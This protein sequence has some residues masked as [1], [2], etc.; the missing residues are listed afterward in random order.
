MGSS[1]A[2]A[3]TA[4]TQQLEREHVGQARDHRVVAHP[5]HRADDDDLEQAA[6]QYMAA[7]PNVT[8]KI[9]VLENEAF[10]A[11]LTTAM[12]AGQSAGPLP[13]LGRRRAEAAGRRRPGQ[14]HHRRDVAPGSATSTRPR[15]G[16][17]PVR[18]QEV[19]RP[20]RPRHGRLLVQQGALRQGRHRRAADHLGRVPRRR[21][22]A[23]GR[24]HHPDRARREGQV[25]GP[26]LLGVPGAAHRRPGRAGSRPARTAR[27]T[28]PASSRPASELKKL[29][30]L[31]AV[32]E[33]LPGRAV[34]RRR[35]RGRARWAT[36]RRRWS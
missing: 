8:I 26:L 3:T 30:D 4:A 22:E 36:A 13:V 29:V 31:Q 15:V 27:S 9:T 25:A 18:R 14:G 12:Q 23:Q 16:A 19:R 24:R 17:L 34:A 1:P 2:G 5:E 10:K 11:K 35:R 6:D 32:P 33:G 21:P 7:H 28:R 20:V